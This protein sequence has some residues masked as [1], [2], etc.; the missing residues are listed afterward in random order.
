MKKEK[1]LL[2]KG[3]LELKPY[4]PGKPI[5]EVKR[6]LGLK[7]VVKLASNETSVGPSPLA[8]EAIIKEAKNS[9][10][11]PEGSSRLLREKIAGIAG[12]R[13]GYGIAKTELIRY[14][15]QVA[16]PFPANRLA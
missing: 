10:L 4:I 16:S 15:R 6:E 13:I 7:E 14:L 2:R 11:Y 9:N 5:E 8:V 12:V 3:I 1:S